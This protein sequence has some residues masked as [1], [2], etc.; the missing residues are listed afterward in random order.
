MLLH[1]KSLVIVAAQALPETGEAA[2]A[3]VAPGQTQ[4]LTPAHRSLIR[5]GLTAAQETQPVHLG[6][7]TQ[8]AV[9]DI[10]VLEVS[11]EKAVQI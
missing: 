3:T 11:L 9:R 6:A 8:H 5:K 10:V 4:I 7:G 2:P 1:N